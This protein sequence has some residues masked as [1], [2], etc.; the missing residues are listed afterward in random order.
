M[1]ATPA[2]FI[3][4]AERA[5]RWRLSRR[6]VHELL[7]TGHRPSTRLGGSIRIRWADVL[8]SEAAGE[9]PPVIYPKALR[10][11]RHRT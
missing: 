2:V 5:A 11:P 8:A 6:T 10:Q 7:A 4:P 3:T 1:P 9:Q